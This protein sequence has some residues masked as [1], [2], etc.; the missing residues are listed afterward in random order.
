MTFDLNDLKTAIIGLATG[1]IGGIIV[2]II[3]WLFNRWWSNRNIKS[4]QRQLQEAEAYKVRL[5][6]LA[7]SDRALLIMGF[8]AI[9]ALVI[10]ICCTVFLYL[11]L[12]EFPT[13]LFPTLILLLLLAIPAVVCVGVVKTL[14]DVREHPQSLERLEGKITDL[15][16]KL[17]RR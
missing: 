15:K 13:Q 4:L 17:L 7:R 2:I 1:I 16:N 10:I 9:F 6:N 5:D 8:Q 14:Q 3:V 12:I 11:S